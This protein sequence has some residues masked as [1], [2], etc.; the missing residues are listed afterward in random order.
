[1]LYFM[2]FIYLCILYAFCAFLPLSVP[3][4]CIQIHRIKV[5][6]LRFRERIGCFILKKGELDFHE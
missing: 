1:M 2:Y 5:Q 3:C 4:V 6:K